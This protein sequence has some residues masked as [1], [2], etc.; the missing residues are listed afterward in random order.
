MHVC[1]G[2]TCGAKRRSVLLTTWMLILCANSAQGQSSAPGLGAELSA[3][4]YL[5]VPAAPPL[6][7]GDYLDAPPRVSLRQF[8]PSPGDQGNQGSCVG[9]ATAY[10]ARTVLE[11]SGRGV[12]TPDRIGALSLSPSYIFNQIKLDSC[13]KGSYLRDA[14]NLMSQQG[15]LKLAEFPY[16][17]EVCDRQ[18]SSAERVAAADHR[19]ADFN[20][21]WGETA[22]NRHIAARRAIS[23]GHP[24]VIGMLAT[25][26]LMEDMDG[27]SDFTPTT[28]ELDAL[29][30]QEH[31]CAGCALRGGHAVTVIGYDDTRD[32]GSFEII[33]SWGSE[34]GEDG[35]F[36]MSYDV[37]NRFAYEGYE[38]LPVQPE[39]PP[40]ATDMGGRMRMLHMTDGPLDARISPHGASYELMRPLASGTRFRVEAQSDHAGYIQVIGGDA[41]GDYVTLFPR[42]TDISAAVL[43]RNSM[44]LPGPTELHFTRLNQTVGTDYYIALFS[45]AQLEIEVISAAVRTGSGGPTERLR[46][47]LGE[48]LVPA[49]DV[50]LQQDGVI[51]FEAVSGTADVVALIIEIDHIAPPLDSI[52]REGPNIVLT[53]PSLEAFDAAIN[54]DM[55]RRVT[56]RDVT[57]RGQAQDENPIRRLNIPG[58][59]DLRFS[60][61]GPF[62]A[63]LELPDRIGP[64][65]VRIVAE[66][67]RGNRSEA[68]IRL[69]L[70]P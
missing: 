18:P 24:V 4:V 13:S 1:F 32:G 56:S 55:P 40:S 9:W 33:N 60:S 14:L 52:D 59:R 17:P 19:I 57:L 46:A 20:R 2:D 64:H 11:A 48:R 16:R 53:S 12:A 62:E 31:A 37:F 6:A 39:L 65:A 25:A 41:T 50:T 63:T 61:R 28:R 23:Q 22:R 43:P 3:D 45:T 21:L 29:Y 54:P 42:G 30:E 66:D 49:R 27:R 47:A 70:R 8:T 36:W 44:L 5:S 58:A 35:Y 67:D 26:S 15:V 51:G 68:E 38:L 69:E 10:A 34:W 7:R